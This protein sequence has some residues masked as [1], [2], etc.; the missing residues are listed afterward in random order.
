MADQLQQDENWKTMR[1]SCECLH[2]GHSLT[3]VLDKETN[4]PLCF[5]EVYLD[6]GASLVERIR[7]AWNAF[8]GRRV[9]TGDFILRPEDAPALMSLVSQLIDKDEA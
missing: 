2:A 4:P 3:A 7:Q 1:F 5:F 9:C 6:G 8:R